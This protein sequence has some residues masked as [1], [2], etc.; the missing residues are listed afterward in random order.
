MEWVY[1]HLIEKV[2][3]TNKVIHLLRIEN[4]IACLIIRPT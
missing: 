3:I 4:N 2:K 1:Y